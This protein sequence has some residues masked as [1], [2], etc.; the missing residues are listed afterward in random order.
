MGGHAQHGWVSTQ[1]L[2]YGPLSCCL[3]LGLIFLADPLTPLLPWPMQLMVF[4]TVD[5]TPPRTQ[6]RIQSPGWL[7]H[8]STIWS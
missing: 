6:R 3:L 2:G 1:H 4:R 5:I 7:S 8:L